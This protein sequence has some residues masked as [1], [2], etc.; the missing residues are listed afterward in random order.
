M[1]E[2]ERNTW[3]SLSP[4]QEN[5]EREIE[6]KVWLNYME[7]KAKTL[8]QL[9][10]HHSTVM[11]AHEALRDMYLK[12]QLKFVPPKPGYLHSMKKST[13]SYFHKAELFL[14]EI[15]NYLFNK[16]MTVE[17]TTD[18]TGSTC[19]FCDVHSEANSETQPRDVTYLSSPDYNST[20]NA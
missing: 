7:Q 17:K 4:E 19:P 18:T 14:H 1:M 5:T 12:T 11:R 8:N 10:F 16:P 6:N 2:T 13:L 9:Y 3:L 20:T 15:W